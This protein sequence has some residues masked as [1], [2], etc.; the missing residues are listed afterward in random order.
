MCFSVCICKVD[1]VIQV[2]VIPLVFNF[3]IH[4]WSLFWTVCHCWECI[5]K[6]FIPAIKFHVIR[7]KLKNYLVVIN[8]RLL[9]VLSLKKRKNCGYW[10]T[11]LSNYTWLFFV[12]FITIFIFCQWSYC[13]LWND[14]QRKRRRGLCDSCSCDYGSMVNI[15]LYYNLY[16]FIQFTWTFWITA[17]EAKRVT[18]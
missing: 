7:M 10:I 12:F 3:Y 18:F 6:L 5:L 2:V 16:T 13:I 14:V 15:C 8:S 9:F 11:Y 17:F 4:T 1:I